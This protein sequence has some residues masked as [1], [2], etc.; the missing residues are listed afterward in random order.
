MMGILDKLFF[1]KTRKVKYKGYDCTQFIIKVIM[2]DRWIP[3]FLSMLKYMQK[4]GCYGSSRKVTFYAD[5]D[6]D[7]RPKFKWDKNLSS[8]AKPVNDRNGDRFYDAG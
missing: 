8:D 4:L 2:R 5:G 6:G 3:H 1:W 7:F